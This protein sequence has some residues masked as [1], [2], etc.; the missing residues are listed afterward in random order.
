MKQLRTLDLYSNALGSAGAV[1]L[2]PRLAAM[3]RLTSVALEDND[4]PPK[5]LREIL[6]SVRL[7]R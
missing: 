5:T 3:T 4:I 7:H 6:N 2:A 1:S